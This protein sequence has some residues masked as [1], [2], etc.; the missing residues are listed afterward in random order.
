MLGLRRSSSLTLVPNC[1]AIENS[2]SPG[3]T[4]HLTCWPSLA[5]RR[6]PGAGRVGR[7]RWLGVVEGVVV[8]AL[9]PSSPASSSRP[10]AGAVAA[11]RA[12]AAGAAGGGGVSRHRERLD[13]RRPARS[14]A[15]ARRRTDARSRRRS[16][17][18][19]RSRS[20]PRAAPPARGMP[21]A[22]AARDAAASA[23]ALPAARS[24]RCSRALH[25]GPG[26]LPQAGGLG[27][28]RAPASDR[29][30]REA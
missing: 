10:A 7:R 3:L 23:A 13:R 8:E 2:V 29:C 15:A 14:R 1:V 5:G 28:R 4:V 22:S 9:A 27:G 26:R 18:S 24:R 17:G 20:R 30:S 12:R 6:R 25:D 16:T 11:G 21:T 19:A